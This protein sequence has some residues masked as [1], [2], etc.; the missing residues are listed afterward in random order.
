MERLAWE[1]R[2]ERRVIRE[3]DGGERESEEQRGHARKKAFRET[4]KREREI[5]DWSVPTGDR[6]LPGSP[7]G[8][9]FLSFLVEF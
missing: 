1:A 5:S 6:L 8:Q 2:R 9:P 4:R 7:T 3:T